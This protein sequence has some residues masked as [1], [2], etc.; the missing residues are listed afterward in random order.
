ML[1]DS[2][3]SPC[4]WGPAVSP[5]RCTERRKG[6]DS[7]ELED[8][9]HFSVRGSLPANRCTVSARTRL[10]NHRLKARK[11][12][13]LDRRASENGVSYTTASSSN[14]TLFN[15]SNG[16][17]A[18]QSPVGFVA[19]N[20][21][22]IETDPIKAGASSATRHELLSKFF[23]LS[24]KRSQSA[25]ANGEV[26]RMSATVLPPI[27][28][29]G[30]LGPNRL[31]TANPPYL[32]YNDP[33]ASSVTQPSALPPVPIPANTNNLAI[34]AQNSTA[35]SYSPA[36]I[37]DDE[38][39]KS[40][41]VA[42]M[43]SLKKGDRILPPCDRCRRLHMDCQKNLT[44]CV[45]C[46]RKH[47][48]CSWKDV[49]ESELRSHPISMDASDSDRERNREASLGYLPDTPSFAAAHTNGVSSV[50]PNGIFSSE[51]PGLNASAGMAG[52]HSLAL[53]AA[54]AA[55]LAAAAQAATGLSVS[56]NHPG[57]FGHN[58]RPNSR[59]ETHHF[60]SSNDGSYR[61]DDLRPSM[62]ESRTT[63]R[64][65][66]ED[67]DRSSIPALIA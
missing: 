38:P 43:E 7:E 63:E 12:A 48:K 6:K 9:S 14:A 62:I 24:D 45:G 23:S 4:S 22:Q 41:M 67:R 8:L 28:S 39:F 40:E 50:I 60:G 46:T 64:Q 16:N 56:E 51:G 66:D 13:I 53:D 3:I 10:L 36:P 2:R 32:D 37:K 27:S 57:H 19:V 49:R 15:G 25:P 11:Q 35:S 26:R 47:A 52:A 58:S 42:R 20:A 17:S 59:V 55:S 44:A 1:L 34:N 18:T 31:A 5:P 61:S 33:F 54:S 30:G 29:S 65:Q 21:R